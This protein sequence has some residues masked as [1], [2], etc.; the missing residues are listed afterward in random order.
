[1]RSSPQQIFNLAIDLNKLKI[2]Q[3]HFGTFTPV[4]HRANFLMRMIE[5]PAEK[6][7][8]KNIGVVV[9]ESALFCAEDSFPGVIGHKFPVKILSTPF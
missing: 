7:K 9:S 4:N 6:R 8:F 3:G 1:M 2:D 5:D